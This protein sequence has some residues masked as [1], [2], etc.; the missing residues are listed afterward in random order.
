MS[1]RLASVAIALVAVALVVVQIAIPGATVFHTWQYVLALAVLGYL[2]V[3][4]AT[5]ALR[6]Q[7]GAAGRMM[8]AGL[9]GVLIVVAAGIASGLLG[10]DTQRVSRAP[11]TIVPLPDIGAAAA[12]SNADPQAIASGDGVVAL[13]R[14]D[15]ADILVTAGSHKFLG[16]LMLMAEPLPAAYF[17]ASDASGNHLTIT[18]QTGSTFLSPVLLFKDRQSI[19][20]EMHFVGSFELPGAKRSVKVVLFD[21]QDVA[22]QHLPLPPEVAGKPVILYDM[23]DSSD[24]SIG[25]GMAP[26]GAEARIGGVLLRATLGTYPQLL[27]A[28]VPA[29]IALVLGLGLFVAGLVGMVVLQAQ[30]GKEARVPRPRG[31]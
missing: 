16:G 24:K 25:I 7:D 21:A 14:R 5:P 1:S 27:I 30:S 10:P 17:D 8:G 6:G 15:R 28:S 19:A 23:F 29:P 18:Q 13:R 26:S 20:G 9:A 3:T 31:A 22:R 4:Y 11:G 12:F 2:V